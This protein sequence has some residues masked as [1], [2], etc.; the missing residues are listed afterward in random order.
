MLGK[1]FGEFAITKVLGPQ[2]INKKKKKR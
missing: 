1:K 2:I